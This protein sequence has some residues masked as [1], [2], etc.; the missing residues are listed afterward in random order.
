MEIMEDQ[1]ISFD[2]AKLA[3]E[4]GFNLYNENELGYVSNQKVYDPDGTLCI[5]SYD[6]HPYYNKQQFTLRK[7]NC[8]DR[9]DPKALRVFD[10]KSV[11]KPEGI[12][13]YF[14]CTQT[15]LQKWLRELHNIDVFA[16]T[17]RFVGYEDIGYYTYTIKS[18]NPSKNY[19]FDNYEDALEV[20]LFEALKLI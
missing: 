17:V 14:V 10:I 18:I 12:D 13:L 3:K 6:S 16:F 11:S 9:N 5:L 4:K 20:G 7:C 8:S 19:R 15:L 1:I 2:T